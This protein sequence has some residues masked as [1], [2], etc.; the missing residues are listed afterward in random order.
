MTIKR[1]SLSVDLDSLFPGEN[2][3]IGDASIIIRPLSIEQIATISKKLKGLGSI[4]SD[5]GVTWENYNTHENL[6]ELAVVILNNFPDILEEASNVKIDDLKVLPIECIVQIVDK[7][8][9]VN[10]KS[11]DNLEKNFKSLTKKFRPVIEKSQ[12]K[13]DPKK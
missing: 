3:K 11:K 9:E 4:L 12:K 5:S 13:V 10:L 2:F 7:I 8:I 6:F 1:Q